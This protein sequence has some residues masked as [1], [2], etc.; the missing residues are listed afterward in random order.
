MTRETLHSDSPPEDATFDFIACLAWR[1]G[2]EKQ[3]ARE[4]LGH[5]MATYEP[6]KT[7]NVC[8]GPRRCPASGF[9]LR[10]G[11]E[12]AGRTEKVGAR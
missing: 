9:F 11:I 1:W 6:V 12:D 5:W 10:P 8:R 2:I 3:A 4:M 7:S